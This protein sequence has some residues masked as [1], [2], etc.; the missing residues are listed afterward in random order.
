MVLLQPNRKRSFMSPPDTLSFEKAFSR[1]EEI[2]EK[3]NGGS[4]SLED[5]I[6]LYE[7]ADKLIQLCS[8]KLIQ[9]EAKIEMLVKN[10]EGDLLLSEAGTPLTQPLLS[11]SRL[12]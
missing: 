11:S 7:E 6:R 3:M 8:G 10:R 12:D 1:L 5:S 9:A 2:L 4:L